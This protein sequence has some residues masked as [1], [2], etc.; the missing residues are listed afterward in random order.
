MSSSLIYQIASII[1]GLITPR[2]ILVAFGSTYNGV[3]SSATQFLNLISILTMGITGATRLAL[4]KTL[5]AKDTVGT[6]RI[7]KAMKLYMRKV[8]LGVI[9]YAAA[10]SILYP[11]ISNSDL[12]Y[13]QSGLLVAIV[14]IG[15]FAQY[16]FGISN[17]TLLNADQSN[18]ITSFLDVIKIISNTI[19]VAILI[20]MGCNIF[21]VKLGS[22]VVYLITPIILE[23]YVKRKYHLISD[24][25]PSKAGL[26]QRGAVAVHSIA[27]IVHDNTA[28]VILTIF[29]DVKLV[30]V[31]TVYYLVVGKI[32]QL[33]Q[34]VTSGM[35]AAFGDMWVKH[36]EKN[37]E[38]NFSGFE[39]LIYTFTAVVFS[40]VG[41][42]IL[43]FIARYTAGVT[44]IEYLRTD[45]A[46]LITVAE[47]IFCIRQPY[48]I[49]VY[50]TGNYKSTYIGAIIEA[51]L[52]ITISLIAVQFW[53][54]V[55]VIVGTLV[56]NSF[57]TIQYMFFISRKVLKRNIVCVLKRMIWCAVTI[58]I[59]CLISYIIIKNIDFSL[60]WF[61]WIFE[62]VIV[63]LV[64]AI[65][66]ILTSVLCYR[67]DMKLLIDILKRAFSK[68]VKQ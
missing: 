14:S 53:G 17:Q 20:S 10:L 26:E 39:Y 54:I 67:K 66:T 65:I 37:L 23:I 68:K 61:G 32:K 8:G 24:C 41:M 48:L 25:K 46:I 18:Y 63:F 58:V 11:F 45:L 62:A 28:L 3:V 47:A 1:C 16:F 9:V 59:N 6:S 33:L 36:E 49:L 4:Y 38:R 40:C 2:L 15:T 60:D 64:A 29:T 19:C 56:A 31:Y 42:L 55:G 21:I 50:A 51:I 5:S 22:S 44:D 7:M 52:N 34:V 35:E 12:P 57:R 43:P 30:S 13:W 27:N